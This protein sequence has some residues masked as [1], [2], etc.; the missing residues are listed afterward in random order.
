MNFE[1]AKRSIDTD[2]IN[3]FLA[4]YLKGQWGISAGFS[5]QPMYLA[6]MRKKLA[7]YQASYDCTHE[8]LA[9]SKELL[10]PTGYTLVPGPSAA[11]LVSATTLSAVLIPSGVD[12]MV[13]RIATCTGCPDI[14]PRRRVEVIEYGTRVNPCT[15][16]L[17]PPLSAY[18]HGCGRWHWPMNVNY[19]TIASFS[20]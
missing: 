12:G 6:L 5:T 17:N 4:K 18:G 13:C 9:E 20:R 16:V 8:L 3:L 14:N 15:H 11:S 2:F 19:V 7:D 1:T 10:C